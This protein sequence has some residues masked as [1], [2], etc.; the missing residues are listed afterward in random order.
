MASTSSELTWIKQL[1]ED[2]GLKVTQP[3]KMYCDNS[4]ARHIAANPVFHERTKHIEIDCHFIWEK[5]QSKEFE[6][7]YVKSEDQLAEILTKGLDTKQFEYIT[8]KLGLHNLYK[9]SLMGSVEK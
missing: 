9:P 1:L 2:L 3:M 5:V 4:A 6:T 7:P 8:Y